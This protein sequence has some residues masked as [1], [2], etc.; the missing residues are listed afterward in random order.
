MTSLVDRYVFTALRRIPQ[1]QRADIDRELRTS[2]QDAVDAQ[3]E[4][5][6]SPQEAIERTLLELGDPDRLADR[7]ADRSTYLI[8][9]ET[10]RVWRRLLITLLSTVL[11]VVVAVT[12]IVQLLEDPSIGKVI[13]VVVDTV[14]T[15]GVHLAF[16]TTLVFAIVDRTTQGRADLQTPW[17]LKDLPKYESGVMTRLELG[18]AV[19]WPAVLIA[20]I[21]LQQF[22]FT[23]V[24]VLDPANWS[25]WWPFLIVVFALRGA[26]YFWVYRLSAWTHKVTAV[27]AVLALL[28]AGPAIWLLARDRFVNP[29][30]PHFTDLQ[31]GHP[32]HWFTVTVI[33]VI[34]V[35]TV[36]D[37]ADVA[38]RAEG[39]R[40]GL[41]SRVPGSGN[42]YT[43]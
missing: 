7:Y 38:R 14:L 1:Q 23:D 40:R 12:V 15:V 27:N 5:G 10:F 3:V 11:P 2:I 6:E 19:A 13:G 32:T 18:S 29:A 17:R 33:A 42:D 41:P 25:F 43:C 34:A 39:A 24:P 4:A 21:V 30:F 35:I 26:Y 9:P 37:I 36:W 31:S 8:G 16:W 20:A 22:T 28:W